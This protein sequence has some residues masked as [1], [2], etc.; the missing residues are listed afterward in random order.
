MKL[1]AVAYGAGIGVLMLFAGYREF[2]HRQTLTA[3]QA[4]TTQAVEIATQAVTHAKQLTAQVQVEQAKAKAAEVRAAKLA[5]TGE[6]HLAAR[7]SL[8]PALDSAKTNT[9]SVP[10]LKA[11]LAQSDAAADKYK[12]A[13]EEQMVAT[14]K[15]RGALDSTQAAQADVIAKA[16]QLARNATQLVSASHESFWSHFV[17]EVGVGGAVGIG[18]N[19]R[20]D[21]V[22][23]LTLS[24][25][26]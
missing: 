11:A 22:I 3:E 9:D 18:M 17:P 12:Q 15:L 8:Q 26:L 2:Q 20:P 13:Y 1:K 4:K 7:G 14:A 6:Q 16:Q 10:V 24:W 5:T 25:R 19:G 23:G 21:A